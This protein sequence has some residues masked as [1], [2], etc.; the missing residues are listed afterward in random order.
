M[1]EAQED[2][3]TDDISFH[4]YEYMVSLCK[5]GKERRWLELVQKCTKISKFHRLYY[6]PALS[7]G[8]YHS[9]SYMLAAQ[10]WRERRM[11]MCGSVGSRRNYGER[12][13]LSFNEE[14]QSGYYQIHLVA[15]REH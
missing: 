15:L 10:C 12:M 5:D 2:R 8:Q 11:I 6:W 9:T 13:P 3:A 1:E 14:I 7:R 4:V